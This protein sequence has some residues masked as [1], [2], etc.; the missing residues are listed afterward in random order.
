MG[1]RLTARKSIV[2]LILALFFVMKAGIPCSLAAR[3]HCFSPIDYTKIWVR[4]KNEFALQQAVVGRVELQCR[5]LL[6]DYL[7]P[8]YP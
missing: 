2:S 6:T 1:N 7:P 3:V 4:F 8:G 5:G